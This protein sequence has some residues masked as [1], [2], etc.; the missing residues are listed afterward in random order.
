MT[1]VVSPK[2]R[3]RMMAGIRGKD[4]L[5]ELR[6]RHY[7]HAAGL[8]YRLHDRRL[9]GCPDLVF[10]AAR[11]AVFVNGCFWHQHPFCKYATLPSNRSEFWLNKLGR[12][13][14]RDQRNLMALEQSGWMPLVIWECESRDELKLDRLYWEIRAGTRATS[15]A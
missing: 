6:V 10:P 4:T 3:S 2:T 14:V 5:P 13:I 12:N 15:P 8:R 7:L 1:D 11:V 9:P